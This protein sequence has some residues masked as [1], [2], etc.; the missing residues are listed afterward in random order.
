[1]RGD[2]LRF[3][4]RV[5]IS[6]AFGFSTATAAENDGVVKD[7]RGTITFVYENDWVDGGKDRNYTNGLRLS[8]ISGTKPTDGISKYVADS[9]M[10]AGEETV[11]RRGFALGH[12]I[13]TPNDISATQNLPDEHPYAAWLYGEYTLLTAKKNLLDQFTVQVGMVGPSAGGEWVQNEVHKRIGA[14]EAQGWDNQIKDEFGVVLSYDRRFRAIA[15]LGDSSFGA[16]ITPSAGVTLGNIQT[17]AR[18]GAMARIGTNLRSDYGPARIRPALAGAGYFTP[19]EQLGW[20]LFAGVEGRYVAHDIFLDGSLLR[21]NGPSVKSETFVGDFQAGAAV[22]LGDIQL[23][24]TY[25]ERSPEFR[26]QNGV[27]R[28]GAVSISRKF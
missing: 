13:F 23:A 3:L 5:S 8:Y 19:I 11:V 1:M 28:F 12:S 16:D 4:L 18:A 17:N 7:P 24:L 21:D 14:D 2:V 26:K 10:G 9:L 22:Q 25:V 20:Y 27:H 6:A 15:T